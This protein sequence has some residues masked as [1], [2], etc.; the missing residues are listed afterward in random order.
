MQKIFYSLKH[1]DKLTYKIMNNGLFFS[2]ILSLI[3]TLILCT[4]LS[5][6][7]SFEYNLGIL[8]IK[9][10]FTIAVEFIV[11]GVIVDFIK[12]KEI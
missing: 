6:G 1:L 5:N 8:L 11:C 7:L 12:N 10:S 9:L 4:Y 3:A 2:F